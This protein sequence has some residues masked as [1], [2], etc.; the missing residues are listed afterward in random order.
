MSK[1]SALIK[2]A[3]NATAA[4][5]LTLA[6]LTPA[7]MLGGSAKAGQ[8]TT[9]SIDMSNSATEGSASYNL[10]FTVPTGSQDEFVLYFCDGSESPIIGAACT[11]P[12]GMIISSADISGWTETVTSNEI[13][14]TN[15]TADQVTGNMDLTITGITNPSDLG[16][17]YARVLT[18]D[19]TDGESVTATAPGNFV[20]YGG[21]ALSTTTD[22]SVNA[23]VQEQ[24][25]FCVGSVLPTNFDSA[26]TG[27]KA[28]N[29]IDTC[30]E[31]DDTIVDLG[32]V[33]QSVVTS[34]AP[35]TSTGNNKTGAFLVFTNAINGVDVSYTSPTSLIASGY[36][37]ACENVTVSNVDQCFNSVASVLSPGDNATISN[38]GFGMKVKAIY[39]EG[40]TDNLNI[41]GDYDTDYLWNTTEEAK[42]ASASNVVDKEVAKLEFAALARTTTPTGSYSTTANFVATAKF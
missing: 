28:N 34:P 24:L 4:L 18:Y 35:L 2:R 16:V 31:I 15:G 27:L 41:F 9:R 20:H 23:R 30:A 21:F 29:D 36:G 13:R 37:G 39:D 33:G 6:S 42:I 19:N 8:V 26:D 5:A 17:F 12:T 11:L 25:T 14:F 40:D 10:K 7:V 22:V 3:S 38:E 1:Y 32:V